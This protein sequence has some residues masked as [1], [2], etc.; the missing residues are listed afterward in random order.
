V[1]V[2]WEIEVETNDPLMAA[3]MALE[4]MR[5]PNSIETIFSM[6]VKLENGGEALCWID[7]TQSVLVGMEAL[8]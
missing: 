2:I 8:Q 4:I 7:A 3:K 6:R 1:R 5:D